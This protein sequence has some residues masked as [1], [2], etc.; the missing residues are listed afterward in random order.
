MSDV[1]QPP[2]AA[3]SSDGSPA[4]APSFDPVPGD[5]RLAL[6]ATGW[7]GRLNAG[8]WLEAADVHVASRLGVLVDEPDPLVVVTLALAVRAVREG[9]TCLDPTEAGA[10]LATA[11]GALD[12]SEGVGGEGV[13]GDGDSSDEGEREG[14]GGEG[15]AAA[16]DLGGWLQRVTGSRLAAESV[17]RVEHGLVYLDR[18]W[19]EERQ[20]ADDL[21]SRMAV[22]AASVDPGLLEA[23][24]DR[25]FPGDSWAEQRSAV[26]A[27]LART[28]TILTGGPGTGKTS[29]VAG[30]VTLLAEQHERAAGRPLRVVL[31]A[32]TGRAAARL[33]ESV[34]EAA[35]GM[36][37]SDRARLEGIES[38]T[39]HR[40]LGWNRSRTRFARDRRNPLPH[41][42]VVVDEASML[43]LTLTARL[44]EAVRPTARLVLV[45]DPDQLASVEAGAVLADLV[46][47]L[48]EPQPTGIDEGHGEDDAREPTIVEAAT[49]SPTEPTEPVL[50]SDDRRLPML[51]PRSPVPVSPVSALRTSHRFGPAIGRLAAAIRDGDP[52]AALAALS[53]EDD[54]VRL[55]ELPATSADDADQT[56]AALLAAETAVRPALLG[57]ALQLRAHAAAGETTAAVAQL[58]EHRLLCAHRDGPWGVSSWVRRTQRWLTEA[59]ADPVRSGHHGSGR[60]VGEPLLVTRNDLG[61]GLF[62]GDPG[63]VV[64]DGS[65]RLVA[66]MD[67]A[68]GVRTHP[69]ARLAD[70]E[71]AHA[72]TVHKSQGSQARTVTVLLPDDGSRLL[73]RELLY[74][75]VT[76][77][78]EQVVL[79][80]SEAAVRAAVIRRT[81]RASGLRRTLTD[82]R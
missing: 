51:V 31:A 38:A 78:Q 57:H 72:S 75:A 62:N 19:R 13:G 48:D 4:A 17:L 33:R 65:G 40:L 45:G 24:L 76:R 16:A 7:L 37:A 22:P 21:R 43:S 30:L 26:R 59:T 32:P 41:D 28:T 70:V 74:T 81:R 12:G 18:Y 36:D 44:L 56:R 68:G 49:D 1:P 20:V 60:Y 23:G 69:V 29:T 9:S 39:V 71:T 27:S 67:A 79:V 54:A 10:I 82:R 14:V 58:G 52:D 15:R 61:L 25:V 34:L 80:G 35:A 55:V 3:A 47:G 5:R 73:T 63:V 11:D 2:E 42:V 6:G 53:S 50:T 77:A 66:A 46:A 64:R 8:G